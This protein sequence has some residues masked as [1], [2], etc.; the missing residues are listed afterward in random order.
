LARTIG[1]KKGKRKGV[2]VFSRESAVGGRKK[3]GK[4]NS[5]VGQKKGEKGPV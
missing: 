1:E 3:G 4:E 5:P 2:L